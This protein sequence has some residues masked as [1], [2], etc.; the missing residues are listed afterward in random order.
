MAEILLIYNG[1]QLGD[2]VDA[3]S[4][5]ILRGTMPETQAGV[6][7]D[8]AAFKDLGANAVFEDKFLVR[9]GWH[10]SVGDTMFTLRETIKEWASLWDGEP[11][12][13]SVTQSGSTLISEPEAHLISIERANA[14][15]DAPQSALGYFWFTFWIPL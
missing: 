13:L 11:H 8:A 15:D 4:P 10:K 9:V 1:V 5:T 14:P 2:G 7:F 12:A 3:I 6:Y